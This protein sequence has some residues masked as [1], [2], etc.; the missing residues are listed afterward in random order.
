MKKLEHTRHDKVLPQRNHRSSTSSLPGKPPHGTPASRV[1]HLPT[2]MMCA[3]N[4]QEVKRNRDLLDDTTKKVSDMR[5]RPSPHHGSKLSPKKSD[6][7]MA[8]EETPRRCL[9]QEELRPQVQSPP[10]GHSRA[11]FPPE[12]RGHHLNATSQ[13]QPAPPLG[14]T[15]LTP[16]PHQRRA[17]PPLPHRRRSDGPEPARS[18]ALRRAPKTEP[19]TAGRPP[20]HAGDPRAKGGLPPRPDVTIRSHERPKFNAATPARESPELR[21]QRRSNMIP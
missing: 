9:Q 14:R 16:R 19:P 2:T 10:V 4:P 20:N 6:P 8:D 3:S 15:P 18:V 11:D 12:L 5:R 17:R 21:H 13:S 7:S 1:G